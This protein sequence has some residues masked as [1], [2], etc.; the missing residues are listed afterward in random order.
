[1]SDIFWYIMCGVVGL[2]IYFEL[3]EMIHPHRGRSN[4][5]EDEMMEHMRKYHPD[6]YKALLEMEKES[7]DNKEVM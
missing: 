7:V 3:S 4:W 6:L 5:T 2:A 1:M